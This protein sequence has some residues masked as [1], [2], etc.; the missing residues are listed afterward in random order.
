V[1]ELVSLSFFF[2]LGYLSTDH[3]LDD[4]SNFTMDDVI[5]EM[6]EQQ[7]SHIFLLL[8][9]VSLFLPFVIYLLTSQV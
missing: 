1:S 8:L 5:C 6:N 7:T 9:Y 2:F 3:T 4:D